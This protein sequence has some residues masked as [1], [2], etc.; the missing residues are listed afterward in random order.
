MHPLFTAL[1]EALAADAAGGHG[2]AV[3]NAYW[4]VVSAGL[5]G[6]AAAAENELMSLAI[7]YTW[8]DGEDDD[9]DGE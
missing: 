3:I 6:T 1:A 9:Y 8:I 2:Q 7:P 5:H 4:A